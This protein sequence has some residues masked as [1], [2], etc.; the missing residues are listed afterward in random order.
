MFVD[1]PTMLLFVEEAAGDDGDAKFVLELP[2]LPAPPPPPEGERIL[3]PPAPNIGEDGG[4]PEKI[5]SR[6][7]FGA[8]SKG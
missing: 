6:F 3:V 2:G 1:P 4:P 5:F 7:S 8:N